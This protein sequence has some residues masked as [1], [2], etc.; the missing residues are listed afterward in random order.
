MDERT[1]DGGRLKFLHHLARPV[2]LVPIL[3]AGAWTSLAARLPEPHAQRQALGEVSARWDFAQWNDLDQEPAHVLGRL[4]HLAVLQVPGASFQYATLANALLAAVVVLCLA[5]LLR[6]AF[7]LPPLA[8]AVALVVSGLLVCSPAF[9]A[10]WLHGERLGIFAVPVLL[11]V[12]LS[13]LQADGRLF[14]RGLLALLLAALAPF[15]HGTGMLVFV[16]LL[17]ALV[18]TSRRAG[19]TRTTAWVT[20]CLL[21]GNVAAALSLSTATWI[22][23]DGTGLLGR[24]AEAPL[25]TLSYVLGATGSAFLDP[26]PGTRIDDLVLGASAWLLPFVLWRLGD[27]S[28]AARRAAAPWWGCSWFGLLVFL[29]LTER[30]GTGIDPAVRR[31][32]AFCTFLLPV[33]ILGVLAARCGGSVLPIAAGMLLVLGL[34]DWHRGLENLRLA[35]M[36]VQ[37]TETAALLPDVHAGERPDTAL[38]VR[39]VAEWR[40]LQERGWVPA[41]RDARLTL[42]EMPMDEA[43]VAEL[44]SCEGGDAKSVRGS[45]RSSVFGDAVQCVIV[46]ARVDGKEP[47]VVGRTQPAYAGRGRDVPWTV[48]LD[49]PLAEGTNVRAFGYRPRHGRTVALG[50]LYVQRSGALV[51][52]P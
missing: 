26:L 23:M 40:L 48:V 24:M 18:D 20:A 50:P 51:A 27:R 39:R 38:P 44:G 30:N 1:P 34:Q 41:A 17:P 12:A 21:I 2:A 49:E 5:G 6:R 14:W 29:W 11:L 28:D 43:A 4:L 22:A 16:G 33:G 32:L 37:R 10:D 45:A 15:C 3:V 8:H 7:A 52:A 35:T 36:Q 9:G 47:T 19:G 31:E 25:A 42:Q 13:L 46:V